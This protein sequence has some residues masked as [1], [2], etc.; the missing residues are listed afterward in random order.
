MLYKHF[1]ATRF[2]VKIGNWNTTKNG[3]PLLNDSWMDDRFKLFE[4]YCLPSVKNQSNQNFVWCIY[5]DINTT[6]IYKNRIKELGKSFSNIHTFYIGS[7]NELRPNLLTFINS[8][9]E[10]AEYIITSRLDTDDLLHKDYIKVV[11]A[12]F[13]PAH[14][15]LLDLR[16]GYQ[17][18]IENNTREIRNYWNDFNPFISLVEKQNNVESIFNKMH[19]DWVDSDKVIV[20]DQSRLWIELVHSKNKINAANSTLEYS[21]K[22]NSSEFGVQGKI[23]I[24]RNINFYLFF[25]KKYTK[26]LLSSSKRIIKQA[27]LS[28]VRK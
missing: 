18:C 14:D 16:S 9:K 6:E 23:E 21:I 2:N 7:I 19:K 5:F 10:D 11:Q 28:D 13:K 8:V 24:N 15:M 1:L 17:V 26:H 25:F 3:E 4:T 27:L 22:F 12:L 20:Y